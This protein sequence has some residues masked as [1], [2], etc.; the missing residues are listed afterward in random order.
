MGA[1]ALLVIGVGNAYA[2]DDGAGLAAARRLCE[3]AG[4]PAVLRELTGEGTALIEAW[5]G[6]DTVVLVD[7]VSSGAPPGTLLYLDAHAEAVPA[8]WFRYSTHAFG[9]AE[10]I[11]LAR[12]LGRLPRRL[13][14]V[15]IEGARFDAGVG[16]SC[17]VAR[18]VDEVGRR[19]LSD[20]AA[21]GRTA[22]MGG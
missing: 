13:I 11:E 19:G 5:D 16:L 8:G 21:L 12:V 1:P 6:A 20:I 7:A 22:M 14:V 17:A 2:R 9:A 3:R 10:A 18:A 15:G 4:A